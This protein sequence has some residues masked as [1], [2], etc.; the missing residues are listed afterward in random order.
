[1]RLVDDDEEVVGEVVEQAVRRLA[2]RPAVDVPRVVLDAGAEADLLHHLEVER[3]AHAQPLRLEQLALALELG[4][5]LFEL[6]ADRADRALHHVGARDVVRAREDRHRIELLRRPGPVSGMQAVERLDLVA[7]H[8]DADGELLVDR[9]DLDRVAA[10]PEVAAREVD[11]VAL[12]LHRDELADEPVA[13]DPL[14]DLQRHHRVE[15]LLGRAEAVD[16]GDRRDHDDVAP[17]QQRVR[18]GVPQPL[19]LGVDRGV[20]L[21][22]GV[23]LR[24]VG[25][26]LVVVVVRDEVLDGVVR[27]ELAELVRELR[28]ERLVVREHERGALHLLDQPGRGRRLAGA[29]RAEQHD[30]GLAGV[31]AAGQLGDRGGLVAARPVVAHDL[32][33]TDGSGGL[34]A[35]QSRYAHRHSGRAP[36]S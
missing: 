31:D 22:E 12:V 34:H 13:V 15:V 3:G 26:G 30:V 33:G 32:E 17:A 14:A 27:H 20:L 8:L 36:E 29:G 9:D 23:G 5:A 4:Q 18:G 24:H 7:E 21:D 6:D 28:G 10:H 25:L 35:F 16:A 19:D 2:R 1:M 11:V